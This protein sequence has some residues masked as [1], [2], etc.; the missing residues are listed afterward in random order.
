MKHDEKAIN[1]LD[2]DVLRNY[3]LGRLNDQE[4]M[5]QVEQ[6]LLLDDDFD[7]ALQVAEDE[8]IENYL[9]GDLGADE[10]ARFIG[11]FLVSEE[12]KQKLRLI[13]NLR[14]YSAKSKTRAVK[15]SPVERAGWF[16]W[17]NL[18]L[19]PA[20]RLAAVILL[21]AGAGL[22]IWRLAFYQS[23][24]DKGLTQLRLAYRGQRPLEA[25]TTA[26]FEYAPPSN[27]RGSALSSVDETARRR[28]ESLLLPATGDAAGARAHQGLGLLF[29]TEKKFDE[30]LREFNLALASA[31]K[32][33]GVY[34]DIGATF[35]EKAKQAEREEKFDESMESKARSLEF[36][37]RALEIEPANREALF[38]KALVLQK[39]P[40][41][42]QA[43]E[44]WEKYLE[45]DASSLWAE[46][47]RRNLEI[48]RQQDGSSKDKSQVLEDFLTAYRNK[49]DARGWK[50]ASQTK[51][52]VTGVM[53]GPQ[54]AEK[55]LEAEK[56][57]RAGDAEQLLSAFLYLGELENKNAK[58]AFF[59][60]W[61]KYYS[62]TSR[63]QRQK[64]I[65][66]HDLMRKGYE[67]LLKARWGEALEGFQNAKDIFMEAGNSWEAAIAEYQICY[68]LCQLKR[69]KESNE[70]LLAVSDWGEGKNYKWIQSLADGWVGNNYSLLGE[71][72]KAIGYG[73]KSLKKAQEISDAYNT[74][75]T[76]NQLAQQYWIVGDRPNTLSS[77]Y[78]S[79]FSADPY[80]ISPRQKSR[81]LLI[82]TGGFYRFKFY[83]AAAA[84]AYEEVY[85]AQNELNDAWLTHTART[86]LALIY[87]AAKKYPEAYR[88][89]EAGFQLAG[90]FSDE[91][92]RQK[93]TTRT[94]LVLSHLQ[95]ESADC[96]AA[97]NNYDSVIQDYDGTEFSISKY[98]A[99]KGRLLCLVQLA[100]RSAIEREMPKLIRM[101]D[102]NRQVIAEESTRNTF[103]DNEQDVYDVATNYAYTRLGDSEQAFD[104]AENSRARS[105]LGLIAGA[106]SRPLTASE[107][108]SN[109]PQGVQ[110][111]FYAVLAEKLLIWQISDTKFVVVE[112]IIGAGELEDKTRNFNRLLHE[113]AESREE[114]KELYRV[115]IQPIEAKIEPGKLLCIVADKSLFRVPFAA[116]VSPLTD[117]YLIEERPVLYSPS[118]TVFIKETE[119]ANRKGAVR[120][121][122][123]LSLGNPSFSRS[124]YP[125]LSDL[126]DAA[127]EAEKIGAFYKYAK[128]V[129]GDEA[130]KDQ[131][132]NNLH[133][134]D[135]L[136]FAG[137]YLPNAKFPVLSK[138][139]LTSGNLE[140]QE[141]TE[142]AL[143][144]TRLIILS[145]CETGVE[146]FYKG[147]GM[148]SAARAFLAADVPLV[149]GSQWTVDSAATAE[150]MIKFHEYRKRGAM[151]TV[152]AL[153]LA[154][155]DMLS[156]GDHGFR[157]PYYWA[158]FMP[159]G[160][161]A[162]Y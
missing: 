107:V 78:N 135:I 156:K 96:Q 40:A 132:I 20:A 126:P 101:F 100:D 130:T 50:I 3:L 77:I 109:F 68:C 25:R 31:P 59:G 142:K 153:R 131:I 2:Q 98:E 13:E 94:R 11:H 16:R 111:I 92:M 117:K 45:K 79:L 54:L 102:E 9:D 4:K 39:L 113:K 43:R 35:L 97:V 64:L 114:A 125:E 118:A 44:A 61:A 124:E 150:L 105:L 21:V 32:D 57:S 147:E 63:S 29:L 123:L 95:R 53:V 6:K 99:R 139:L 70:K 91:V 42:E 48:I 8:L 86:Q 65:Q 104:Y 127:R 56:Q 60:E 116:L 120:D 27:T 47:A 152:N 75:R 30:A 73:Q 41:P 7:E 151:T 71:H 90:S 36:L 112:K 1:S 66:S 154:Q 52:M 137:H 148:I 162:N 26:D 62:K 74:Q 38:N 89:L 160:G 80:F 161:Y 159:V 34:S 149:V 119:I 5:R 93:Q 136:H 157:N 69:I 58:D 67:L 37:N 146:A 85:V 88:E 129:L 18:S 12:R 10:Q 87:A 76:F 84:L 134:T 133:E 81:N 17:W 28:A 82:A 19:S 115:L 51:E 15:E 141:I 103:F 33:V 108:R 46:E 122:V 145:A 121:E 143:P 106:E 14:A 158:G 110:I 138:L 22:G 155:I 24:V 128:V 83:D 140:V 23:D 144:R 55:F 72:S 49:D